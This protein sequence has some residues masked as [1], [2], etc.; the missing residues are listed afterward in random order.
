MCRVASAG[1]RTRC[2]PLESTGRALSTSPVA[3]RLLPP[4]SQLPR[5]RRGRRLR[6][7]WEWRLHGLGRGAHDDD[8][9]RRGR[10]R[11]WHRHVERVQWSWVSATRVGRV[12]SVQQFGLEGTTDSSKRFFFC[13]VQIAGDAREQPQQGLQRG[14]LLGDEK[15]PYDGP[16]CFPS[17]CSQ[18]EFTT[19][20]QCVSDVDRGWQDGAIQCGVAATRDTLRE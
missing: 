12:H 18:G 6:W 16:F 7:R 4:L 20:G 15:L 13:P 1:R 17:G 8:V 5:C 19:E 11:R 9:G 2:H 10:R 14:A 3:H